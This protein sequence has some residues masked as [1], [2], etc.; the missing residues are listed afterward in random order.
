MAEKLIKVQNVSRNRFTLNL[1]FVTTKKI[2]RLNPDTVVDI[3]LE[4]YTYLTTQC[5]GAFEKGKLKIIKVDENLEI[6]PIESDNVMSN[7]DIEVLMNLTL[8]KLKTKVSEITTTSLLKDIRLKA[9]EV[10]K[11]DKFIE[12]I[13]S[14][15]VELNN[16]S[17]L[18]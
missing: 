11:Q 18:I 10:G 4:E 16:G 14:R 2:L 8:P 17:I 13:D 6:T 9:V 7:E 5:P 15:I 3:T 1:S 12:V